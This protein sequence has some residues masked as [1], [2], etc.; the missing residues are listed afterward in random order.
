M[1]KN[2]QQAKSLVKDIREYVNTRVSQVKLTIAEKLSQLLSLVI[3]VLMGALVFFM[4]WL[5]IS[6][7]GA[8]ALGQ[9]LNNLVLGF[10]LTA[11]IWLLVGFILW[12]TRKH[13]LNRPII[14][15]L[16][17]VFFKDEQDEKEETVG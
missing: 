17:E 12:I 6:I 7:A 13:W 3:S 1:D 9:W 15:A 5:L 16:M 10:L 2:F 14:H 11:G 4:L 8:I